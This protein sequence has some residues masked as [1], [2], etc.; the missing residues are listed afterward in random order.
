MELILNC[1][2][3]Q[4]VLLG[5][6]VTLS[7]QSLPSSH[8]VPGSELVQQMLFPTHISWHSSPCSEGCLQQ[9][10]VTLPEGFFRL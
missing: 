7:H 5:C 2:P 3:L 8:W 1:V 4:C 6:F 9:A 10:H